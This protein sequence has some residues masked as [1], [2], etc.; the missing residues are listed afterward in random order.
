M[1]DLTPGGVAPLGLRA[2][3]P[4]IFPVHSGQR[5][6]GRKLELHFRQYFTIFQ[7]L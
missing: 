7:I 3:H 6:T 2:N 4:K 5:I 1:T